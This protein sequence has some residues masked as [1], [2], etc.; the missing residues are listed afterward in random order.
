M[1]NNTLLTDYAIVIVSAKENEFMAGFSADDD[2]EGSTRN[3]FKILK[4]SNCKKIVVVVNKMDANE[5]NWSRAIFEDRVRHVQN[6]VLRLFRGVDI[7]SFLTFV[8]ASATHGE[9]VVHSPS[10]EKLYDWYDGL[11]VLDTLDSFNNM[12][13][14]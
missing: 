4:A 12:P 10:K 3:H 8:P 5:I 13:M 14:L 7:A 1:I 11:S 6:F 9:N 2:G